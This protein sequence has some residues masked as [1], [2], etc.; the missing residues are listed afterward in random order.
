MAH[1]GTG[2]QGNA[3]TGPRVNSSGPAYDCTPAIS[4]NRDFPNVPL[5]T[6]VGRYSNMIDAFFVGVNTDFANVSLLVVATS[7]YPSKTSGG[8]NVS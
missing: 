8:Q 2:P 3:V 5:A 1:S 6:S 4:V 7:K